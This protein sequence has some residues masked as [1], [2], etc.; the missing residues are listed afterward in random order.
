MH[1]E[2][3]VV[4]CAVGIVAAAINAVAGGGPILTLGILSL[5][6][7]DPRIANLTST[8]ALS[9]G[10]LAAGWLGKGS[11]QN[12]GFGPPLLLIGLAVVGG[13]M[14]AWLLLRTSSASFG[15]IVPWLV[16]IATALYGWSSLRNSPQG[17]RQSNGKDK[18][19]LT[20]LFVPLTIYGGYFG[21]GNSFLVLALLGIAGHDAKAAGEAKNAFIAA[22]NAGAVLVF[23]FSGF[24]HWGTAFALGLGGLIGSVVGVR[25][26]TRMPVAVIR[27]IVLVFGLFFAA[28]MFLR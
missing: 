3:Y 12:L 28:W 24:V 19:M 8:V 11:L 13:A 27:V 22:V 17:Q 23:A 21:G 15:A 9:P 16:L 5:T 6:G 2:F 20:A 25:L 18:A 26:L 1:M 7:V 14:G 4:I 10:Q